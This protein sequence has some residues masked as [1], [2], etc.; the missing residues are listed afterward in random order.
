MMIFIEILKEFL[1][2]FRY[3]APVSTF[4]IMASLVFIMASSKGQVLCGI[5]SFEYLSTK[6]LFESNGHNGSALELRNGET[7]FTIHTPQSITV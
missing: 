3:V 2:D 6:P 1:N 5:Q 7:S 4:V